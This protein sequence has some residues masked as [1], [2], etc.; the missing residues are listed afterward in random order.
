[1]KH[2][3]IINQ[4]RALKGIIRVPGDKSISHRALIFASLAQGKSIIKGISKCED[5]FSTLNCLKDLGIRVKESRENLVIFGEGLF[6]FKKPKKSLDCGNSGTTMRL[7]AGLLAAQNFS[8]V[9]TGD[10][11]LRKRPM[12]RIV[13]PLRKLGAEIDADK[14]NYPPLRIK[15]GKLQGIRYSSPIASA[16]VKSCL[17]LAGLH[18]EGKT[19]VTEPSRSRDHTERMLKYFG[20]PLKIQGLSVSIRKEEFAGKEFFIP[21]DISS[22]AFFIAAA[23]I[24]NGSKIKISGIGVNPTRTGFLDVLKKMGVKI[25]IKNIKEVCREPIADLIVEGN[26][27]LRGI[28]IG[29]KI[30]PRIIDEIPILA[31][32]GCFAR[33]KTIIKDAGELRVKETD[34][35]HAIASQLKRLGAAIKER[36]DGM[37][38]SGGKKLKGATVESFGDHR[39]AMALTIAGLGAIGKTK[40]NDTDCIRTSFPEFEDLLKTLIQ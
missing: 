15:G 32:I 11:Y 39:T 13:E 19:T 23:S 8:S 12:E 17:L 26:N 40:V 18:A 3:I 30:I 28:K 36:K 14:G 22:T 33:G 2:S 4:V 21:G 25:W 37:E 29:G 16:Q 5:C 6:A 31:V 35:I 27:E 9:L 7:L 1:M 10:K 20:V 34:R 38:I 24:L